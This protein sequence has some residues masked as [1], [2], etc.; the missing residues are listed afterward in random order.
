MRFLEKVE[1]QSANEIAGSPPA[2]I[3]ITQLNWAA[4]SLSTKYTLSLQGNRPYRR[5]A[6]T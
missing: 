6:I 1:A 2:S 3:A 5:T 4:A